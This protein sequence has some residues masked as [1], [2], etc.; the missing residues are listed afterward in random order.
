MSVDRKTLSGAIPD[1]LSPQICLP[2]LDQIPYELEY[3]LK[4]SRRPLPSYTRCTWGRGS[5]GEVVRNRNLELGGVF[6]LG[7]A[8][9]S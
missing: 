2:E 5:L 3:S 9:C 4:R 7:R 1:D 6:H 8:N